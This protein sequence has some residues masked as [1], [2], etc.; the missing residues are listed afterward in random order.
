MNLFSVGIRGGATERALSARRRR[1]LGVSLGPLTAGAR[2]T[3]ILAGMRVARVL[4]VSSFAAAAV[5]LALLAAG[6]SR[7]AQAIGP[8]DRHFFSARQGLSV[9][10]PAGWTLSQHTGY[11]E[12]VVLLLHPDGSRISV[13]AAPT[14]ARDAASLFEQ[15]R[16]GLVAQ[17]LAPTGIAAGRRGFLAVDIGGVPNHAERIRQLY[18]VREIPT[19]RQAIILTL[20]CRAIAL[21]A[22]ASA[23]D[24]VVDRI[25]FEDPILPPSTARGLG[26]PTTAPAG[27]GS[28]GGAPGSG[29]E[30]HVPAGKREATTKEFEKH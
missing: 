11:G 22:H 2:S 1:F 12:T 10:A 19:G 8:H 21:P 4:S 6:G 28:G 3:P 15:S 13:T 27:G 7:P 5:F 29:G 20:V 17:G 25:G 18:L 14:T 24:F 16:P 23:L 26:N 9:E 30:P